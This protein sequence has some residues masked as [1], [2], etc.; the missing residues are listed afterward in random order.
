MGGLIPWERLEGRIRP[1][2]PRRAG[3]AIRMPSAMLRIPAC[4]CST[5]SA[6][7]HGGPAVRRGVGAA[8]RGLEAVGAAAGRD[9]HPELPSS[10][11][12]A[13]NWGRGCSRR[14]GIW[15]PRDSCSRKGRSWTRA[16]SRRRR[17]RRIER[18]RETRR[19]TSEEG[20]QVA[21]RDEGA[22]GVDAETG[23]VHSVATTPANVN[24]VTEA[25]RLL[26]GGE[27]QVWGDAGYQGV[28]KRA[29]HPGGGAGGDA[30]GPTSAV[31]AGKP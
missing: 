2:T 1:S 7:P 22:I 18:V 25:H 6:T 27:S 30:A 17:R 4:S 29:E 24:D 21:F 12:G 31:G 8:V 5:T 9:H 13:R 28:Q 10:V 15:R 16:S 14:S 20:E 11:G 26:H 19:C 23:V 3:D